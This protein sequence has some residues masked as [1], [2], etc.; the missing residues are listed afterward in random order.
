MQKFCSNYL[1]ECHRQRDEK[2]SFLL[3][4][5]FQLSQ[6]FQFFLAYSL[7]KPQVRT[8]RKLQ[9]EDLEYL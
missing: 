3:T 6:L 7:H 1:L 9:R 8:E 4:E 2:H 5:E